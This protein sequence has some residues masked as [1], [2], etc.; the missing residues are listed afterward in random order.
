MRFS[1]TF[2]VR[3]FYAKVRYSMPQDQAGRTQC[4]PPERVI[5]GIDPGVAIAGYAFLVER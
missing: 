3:I 4:S 1:L 2:W 5:L